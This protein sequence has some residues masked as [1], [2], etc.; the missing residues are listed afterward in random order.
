M[1]IKEYYNTIYEEYL[2]EEWEIF[3]P[4]GKKVMYSFWMLK[5]LYYYIFFLPFYP[6]VYII[7]KQVSQKTL[8]SINKFNNEREDMMMRLMSKL[9]Q[10]IDDGISIL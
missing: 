1:I 8:D 2:I 3:K 9:G 10:E 6:L 4:W 7:F 5:V